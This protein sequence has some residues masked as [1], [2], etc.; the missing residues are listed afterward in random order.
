MVDVIYFTLNC[1]DVCFCSSKLTFV[2]LSLQ[3]DKGDKGD[4]GM[5]T[6]L[7]AGELIPTGIIEGPPGPPG[8]PGIFCLNL[9]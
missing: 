3:G 2:F 5:T 6:T 9:F 8:P 4:R 7:K 1:I